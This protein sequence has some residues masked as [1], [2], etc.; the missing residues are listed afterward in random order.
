M[1]AK[2]LNILVIFVAHPKKPEKGETNSPPNLYNIAGSGDWYNMTDYGVII[3]R[4]RT[5]EGKLEDIVEIDIQ[6]IKNFNLGDPKG[7]KVKLRFN[8][9]NMNIENKE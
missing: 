1:L 9:D 8:K 2:R 7:G 6:K 4:Q 5:E 3:H